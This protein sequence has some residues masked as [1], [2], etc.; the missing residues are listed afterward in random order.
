MIPRTAV[1]ALMLLV[2]GALGGCGRQ[3]ELDRP[4]YP[5]FGQPRTPGAERLARDVGADRA[6]REGAANADP[7]APISI[8][9]V[10][11]QPVLPPP[12]SAAPPAPQ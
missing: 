4:A 12:A 2:G 6:R 5:L 1:L 3:A 10:R 9:E 7:R 11:N 8:D